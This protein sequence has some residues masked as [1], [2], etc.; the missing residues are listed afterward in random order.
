MLSKNI[1]DDDLIFTMSKNIDYNQFD[2]F[3]NFKEPKIDSESDSNE[4]IE[5]FKIE[6]KIDEILDNKL[7]IKEQISINK[8]LLDLNNFHKLSVVE[9]DSLDNEEFKSIGVDP[10]SIDEYLTYAKEDYK[11]LKKHIYDTFNSSLELDENEILLNDL[12]CS[13][14]Q[15]AWANSFKNTKLNISIEKKKFLNELGKILFWFLIDEKIFKSKKYI[16]N[17]SKKLHDTAFYVRKNY[18]FYEIL[19]SL[20]INIYLYKKDIKRSFLED[21]FYEVIGT[22]FYHKDFD[23]LKKIFDSYFNKLDEFIYDDYSDIVYKTLLQEL[24]QQKFGLPE[25]VLSNE[26]GKD[27]QKIFEYK[28]FIKKELL[29]TGTSYSKKLAQENSAEEA[30]KYYLQKYGDEKFI[31][32]DFINLKAYKIKEFRKN[33]LNDLNKKFDFPINNIKLLDIALTHFTYVKFNL[34]CRENSNLS[35][36]GAS[37]EFLIRYYSMTKSYKQLNQDSLNDFMNNIKQIKVSTYLEKFFDDQN[38]KKYVLI[39]KEDQLSSPFKISVVQS[40][41]AVYYLDQGFQS[42]KKLVDTIWNNYKFEKNIYMDYVG[43]LQ[44]LIQKE[45]KESKIEYKVLSE[46][47]KDHQKMFEIGC[48]I[49]DVVY[50]IGLAK[51]KKEGRRIAAQNTYKDEKFIM[52]FLK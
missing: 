24:T 41:I 2:F 40:L 14:V 47:G 26:S 16:F 13:F 1:I 10:S 42:A 23:V 30:V 48:L 43:E 18:L 46:I 31:E 52:V 33:E 32:Q 37:L 50:G 38:L 29:G 25:Y 8:T 7:N 3:R 21:I 51:N 12:S 17:G 28:V 22:I 9:L 36:L 27:N 44:D 11:K 19:K 20:K 49:D 45:F 6:D 15:A 4:D 35:H 34:E 5:T 39:T